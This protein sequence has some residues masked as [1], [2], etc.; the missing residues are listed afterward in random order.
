[1]AV[2]DERNIEIGRRIETRRKILNVSSRDLGQI[3]GVSYQQIYK[4]E[5]GRDRVS[6]T[7]LKKIAEALQTD[8]S[9][10]IENETEF[11]EIL[12]E[13]PERAR[14]ID[15]ELH[16]IAKNYGR[17]ADHRIRAAIQDLVRLI[18]NSKKP[19]S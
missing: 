16:K 18:A 19:K 15:D 6:I 2:L 12:K 11:N 7:K 3:L 13:L 17:I 5:C 14:I 1:M 9:Y 4:Y 8:I 10:F